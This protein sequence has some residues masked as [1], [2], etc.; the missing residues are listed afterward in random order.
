MTH[1]G[2]PPKWEAVH[3]ESAPSPPCALAQVSRDR[4]AGRF[5]LAIWDG[6]SIRDGEVSVA[7]KTVSGTVDQAA[8]IVWRYRDSGNYYVV[9]ANTLESNIVLYKVVN[10]V[11]QTIAPKG[12][13]S[14][15]YGIKHSIPGGLWSTLRVTFHGAIFTVFFNEVRL[16]ETEDVTFSASGQDRSLDQSG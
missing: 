11:R 15:A 6:P 2:D 14:R 16:F 1:K 5:P 8:G 7:F 4:T 10:G 3:D 12:M 13:P 9:R